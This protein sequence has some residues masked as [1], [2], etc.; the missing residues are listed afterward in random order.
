VLVHAPL[1]V[2]KEKGRV[3]LTVFVHNPRDIEFWPEYLKKA[4]TMRKVSVTV[5]APSGVRVQAVGVGGDTIAP[6]AYERYDYV[7]S[8]S[9]V[10]LPLSRAIAIKVE[11]SKSPAAVTAISTETLIPRFQT[12]QLE[13][14]VEKWVEPGFRLKEAARPQISIKPLVPVIEKPS[15]WIDGEKITYDGEVK[16]G[17]QLVISPDGRAKIS[18]SNII[19]P[20]NEVLRDEDSPTGFRIVEDGYSAGSY[21]GNLP[22]ESGRKYLLE[23]E[24]MATGGANTQVGLRFMGQFEKDYHVDK[25]YKLWIGLHNRFTDKWSKV[26]HTFVLPKG[27]TG[28]YTLYLYRLP[29]KGAI[30][31][32]NF[33]LIRVGGD[34]DVSDSIRGKMPLLQ[35][36]RLNHVSYRDATGDTGGP[37]VEVLVTLK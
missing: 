7:L 15:V 19:G 9:G 5:N 37:R 14:A 2:L 8:G 23:F 29:M 26:S 10:N 34:R 33:S 3:P 24:G 28:L 36:G 13:Y 21:T 31:Y 22:L 20:M 4:Q 6:G 17:R 27:A 11:C 25:R 1:S 18:P 32:G 30:S 12:R 16:L 35:P